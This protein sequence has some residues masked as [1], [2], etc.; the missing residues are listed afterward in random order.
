MAKIGGK[1]KLPISDSDLKKAIVERNNSLNV[2]NKNLAK[3]I[4]D[5]ENELKALE[6]EYNSNSK[7]YGKLIKEIGFQQ[8]RDTKLRGG[9]YSNEKLL[10]KKLKLVSG[11]E[12]EYK[13]YKNDILKLEEKE[14]ELIDKIKNLEFYKSKCEESKVELAN[15]QIKKDNALEELKSIEKDIEISIGKG[16]DKIAYYENKYN[17]LEEQAKKHE[18]MVSQFESRLNKTQNLLKKEKN[19]LDSF[20]NNS[21][22]QKEEAQN[23][24]QAIK[25]LCNDTEDK[26]IQWEA[27]IKKISE[28][29]DKE[30]DRIKKAKDNFAQ[31]KIGVL[32]EVARLK[33]KNKVD[34]ID[35]AG[36]SDILNG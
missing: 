15:I 33:L 27:K 25:N 16:E 13:G 24:L 14:I 19:N 32:E 30:Q 21:K 12:K 9:I 4:K 1:N 2:K 5:K 34:N 26:Y 22:T 10:S 28:K 29:A 17:T 31:W 36:L 23:E 7:E 11:A 18:E 3:L 6:K 35:K 20:I 8:E